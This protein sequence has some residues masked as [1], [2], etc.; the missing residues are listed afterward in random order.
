MSAK[1]RYW[2]KEIAII[3]AVG[4]LVMV[5]MQWFQRHQQRGGGGALV[6]G[7][8]AP[9]FRADELKTG[10]TVELGKLRGK[11]VIVSFW[12]TYCGPCKAQ[13]DDLT[14]VFNEA[15]DRYAV[16]TVNKER[17]SKVT[18]FA[19]KRALS[20]PIVHDTTGRIFGKYQVSSIPMTVIID[21]DG[22]VVHDFVGPADADILREHMETLTQA[23]DATPAAGRASAVA[24]N[25]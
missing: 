15:G 1:L 2:L 17:R 11:P 23:A 13:I 3:A 16:V 8:E 24:S 18:Q 9:A 20:F 25:P 22:K 4:G 19:K 21:R 12:A 10:A 6:V 7:S 5:G 14:E